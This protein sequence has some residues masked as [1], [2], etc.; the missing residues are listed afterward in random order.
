M[1][2]MAEFIIKYWLEFL[3]GLVVAGLS[4]LC[5]KFYTLYKLEKEHQKT[6]EQTAF[7]EGI[8]ETIREVGKESLKGDQALQTQINAVSAGILSIQGKIFK[9]ECRALLKDGH[10]VTLEEFENLQEEH[11]TY[12]TLGGNH[13]GDTLFTM[14][15]KK[16]TNSIS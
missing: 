13:D 1:K 12:K 9:N 5:K 8:K 15:E 6:K 2:V 7:Y 10:E 11:K 4:F 3:F 14:V 16:V